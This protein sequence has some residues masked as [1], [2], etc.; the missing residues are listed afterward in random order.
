MVTF[1]INTPLLTLC[2][3]E[4]LQPSKGQIQGIQLPRNITN[5]AH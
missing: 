5:A 2:H 4:M 3:T 1:V